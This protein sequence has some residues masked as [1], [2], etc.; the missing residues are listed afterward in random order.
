M[1]KRLIAMFAAVGLLG[2]PALALAAK[3]KP[4]PPLSL[5]AS[6]NPFTVLFGH[7]STI[8]G[9]LIGHHAAGKTVTL[10]QDVYPYGDGFLP[11]KTTTTV[12]NGTYSFVVTPHSNVNYR[13]R[14]AGESAFTGNRVHKRVTLFVSDSTPSRGQLVRFHGF[15]YPR[16]DGRYLYIQRR[17]STGSFIRA[18][19]TLTRVSTH[20]RSSFSTKLRIFRSGTYRAYI[21]GDGDHLTGISRRRTLHRS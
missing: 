12:A 13:L 21:A 8:S 20:T 4:G 11:L 1:M 15:V 2:V 17:T 14:A 10:S 19:R 7:Q 3:T 18:R 6:A 5:S 16:H 9:S